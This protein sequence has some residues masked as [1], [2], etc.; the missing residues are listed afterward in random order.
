MQ[1]TGFPGRDGPVK[2]MMTFQQGISNP[3]GKPIHSFKAH[4]F[5]ATGP[6]DQ[7]DVKYSTRQPEVRQ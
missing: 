7:E 5:K 4:S 6:T 1:A 3:N 2:S